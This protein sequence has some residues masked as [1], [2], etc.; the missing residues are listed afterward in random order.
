MKK[1]FVHWKLNHVCEV[2]ELPLA[3]AVTVL[4]ITTNSFFSNAVMVPSSVCLVG[5][6]LSCLLRMVVS[7][8]PQFSLSFLGVALVFFKGKHKLILFAYNGILLIL[9]KIAFESSI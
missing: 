3:R 2:K 8:G 1:K 6:V 5:L 7:L 9:K 4:F